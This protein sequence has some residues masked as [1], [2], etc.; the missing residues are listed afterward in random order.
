MERILMYLVA[1]LV[2][3]LF[4]GLLIIRAVRGLHRRL[5]TLP[6]EGEMF[7]LYT[8]LFLS[9]VGLILLLSY[10]FVWS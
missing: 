3:G 2:A 9:A 6:E 5:P 7:V 8:G 10:L 4:A 1:S